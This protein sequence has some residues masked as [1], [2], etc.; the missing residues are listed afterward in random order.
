V[1]RVKVSLVGFDDLDYK[2]YLSRV[3]REPVYFKIFRENLK[4]IEDF[5]E[6]WKIEREI[7]DCCYNCYRSSKD[8][9]DCD[10]N[11]YVCWKDYPM[12]EWFRAKELNLPVPRPKKVRREGYCQFHIRRD[13]VNVA[14]NKSSLC[15]IQGATTSSARAILRKLGYNVPDGITENLDF[16][17][18]VREEL[19]QFRV[20]WFP[21][22][23]KIRSGNKLNF[24]IMDAFFK[25]NNV[26]Y[27]IE[28]K[29]Y[30]SG[31]GLDE[32]QILT[33]FN[34]LQLIDEFKD[35]ELYLI[36]VYPDNSSIPPTNL[37]LPAPYV[38]HLEKST[39]I[40]WIK[41]VYENEF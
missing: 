19:N 4:E 10:E 14:F 3:K 28:V 36:L 23:I 16:E 1:E 11:A 6:K 34:L 13:D 21:R 38:N 37:I 20:E 12:V 40:E 29:M 33:Y 41:Y 31:G 5:I 24:K 25:L 35:K 9:Y 30:Y 17:K 26:F 2:N 22:V 27:L 8:R 7:K 15:R 39:F 18:H 32:E